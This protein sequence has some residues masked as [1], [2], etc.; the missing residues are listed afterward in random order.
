M[1]W[2]ERGRILV[3][4]PTHPFMLVGYLLIAVILSIVVSIIPASLSL[5]I[6]PGQGLLLGIIASLL[7]LL[8]PVLSL[9]NLVLKRIVTTSTG[10][11]VMGVEFR[12]VYGIPV[13]VPVVLV[14]RR[15]MTLCINLGGGVIPLTVSAIFLY[16]LYTANSFQGVT[17]ALYSV[18]TTSLVTYA[19]SRTIP[20]VGIVV[21][22]L[23][24]PITSS[25][26]VLAL[27]G[28]GPLS[29]LAAYVGGS[30]GSLIGADVIRLVRDYRKIN[31]PL[32]SIGGAGVF[33]GVFVSGILGL[34]LA[35]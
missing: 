15:V 21:P 2:R 23:I 30:L 18:L 34:L 29:G 16:A 26:T 7:I 25:L 3:Y 32:V 24:P 13:P 12:M 27:V 20:G 6:D 5:A 4:P 33:D 11:V 14:S 10:E 9:F 35:L 8:S 1:M 31:S 22:A 19:F 28:P 17:P